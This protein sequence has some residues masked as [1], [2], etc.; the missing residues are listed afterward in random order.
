M[1][2]KL[3]VLLA[4]ICILFVVSIAAL[5]G[6]PEDA[7]GYW[8]YLPS[9]PPEVVKIVGDN[10]FLS[11]ADTGYWTG[12]FNG[13]VDCS[14]FKAPEDDL[15]EN[16]GEST[17]IGWVTIHSNDAW[18]YR[19]IVSLDPVTVDGKTGTLEMR[20]SG[21]RPDAELDEDSEWEGKWV[22]TGGSGQLE[23]L[24][25][26]GTWE[27]PGYLGGADYGIIR[28]AGNFHFESD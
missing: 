14:E 2:K 16:C 7:Q 12:T 11:I 8:Y 22:I 1:K 23:G 13:D 9:Q 21:S 24:R 15:A 4:A 19:G 25:G 6:P 10:T 17:D 27:G 20:V 26:Q 28:Y 18:F 5:A 3:F